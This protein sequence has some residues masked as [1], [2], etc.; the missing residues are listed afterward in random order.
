ML[1]LKYLKN[2]SVQCNFMFCFW[3]SYLNQCKIFIMEKV[4]GQRE[5]W[6]GHITSVTVSSVYRRDKAYFVDLFVRAS[7][8]PAIKMYEVLGYI[9]YRRVLRY[10][11][12]EEDGLGEKFVIPL[13]RPIR[14]DELEYDC[15]RGTSQGSL[16]SHFSSYSSS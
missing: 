5:S 12:G 2:V 6:H 1:L 8:M 16:R 10:Y 14:P 4:E 11:S 7:S 9:I 13:R 15:L 3:P